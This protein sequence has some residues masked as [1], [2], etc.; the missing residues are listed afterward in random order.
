MLFFKKWF[1]AG[2]SGVV[3]E[4][5]DRAVED[6]SRGLTPEKV[7]AIMAAANSGVVI[8]S[9]N[10]SED[11]AYLYTKTAL[12]SLEDLKAIS[13][14]F[15]KFEEV[16]MSVCVETI[17]FHPGAAKALKEAGICIPLIGFNNSTYGEC[18][19]PA[20]TSVDNM[21]DMICPTA[22]QLLA[23]RLAGQEAPQKILFSSRL[24]ERETFQTEESK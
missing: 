15:D 10:V 11:D 20:L 22:V 2:R 13:T 8:F 19:S 1:G 12:E 9:A 4:P 21:L 6:V 5:S 18:T 23:K 17:P 24:V 14:Y 3:W 7:D 16:A